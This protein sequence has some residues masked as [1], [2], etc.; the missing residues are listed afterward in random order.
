MIEKIVLVGIGILV[1]VLVQP[2]LAATY[3]KVV[4]GKTR[5]VQRRKKERTPKGQVNP[6]GK[7]ADAA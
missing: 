1:G 3:A 2:T 7:P 5:V 6:M 4:L